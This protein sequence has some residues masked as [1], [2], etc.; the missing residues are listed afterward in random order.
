M[1]KNLIKKYLPDPEKIKASKSLGFLG[2][3]LHDPCLW[4]LTRH[5]VKRAFLF[6]LFW[7]SIP[8]PFQMAA[9]AICAIRFKANLALS[10]ALVWL[11]NPLTMG[12]VFYFEYMI[13]AWLLDMPMLEFEF[14]ASAA[15]LKA[16]LYEIGLP[17]FTGSVVTGILVGI[18]GYF[19]I[20][21]IWKQSVRRRWARRR[22]TLRPPA[23]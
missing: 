10:V 18:I 11:T 22:E 5:S 6:G 20:D 23:Q 14:E 16:K 4:H 7:A 9:S 12:P 15:W 17:L 13:G 2:E 1:P 21:A 8:I 3:L 19:A